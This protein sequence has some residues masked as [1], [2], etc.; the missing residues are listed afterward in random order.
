[1]VKLRD[2]T[3]ENAAASAEAVVGALQRV[4]ESATFAKAEQSRRFLAYVTHELSLI[5]I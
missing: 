1:M 4:L 2:S 3:D 5:H